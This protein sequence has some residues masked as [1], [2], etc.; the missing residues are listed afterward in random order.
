[1]TV[2]AILYV[3]ATKIPA[4]AAGV[5]QWGNDVNTALVE[6]DWKYTD[7]VLYI[8]IIVILVLRYRNPFTR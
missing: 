3:I 8:G 1:L 7:A 4:W 2:G 5:A 6:H